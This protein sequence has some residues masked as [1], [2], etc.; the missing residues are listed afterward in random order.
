M[1]MVKGRIEKITLKYSVPSSIFV[2]S[3]SGDVKRL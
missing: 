2:T 1:C 3:D